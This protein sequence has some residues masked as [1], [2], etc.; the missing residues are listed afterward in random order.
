MGTA[1]HIAAEGGWREG[2]PARDVTI[3]HN[4]ILHCG[5]GQQ[6]CI[7]GASAVCVNIDAEM[8]DTPGLHQGIRIEHNQIVAQDAAQGVYLSCA[9]DVKVCHNEFSG[10]REAVTVRH[11]ER[12]TV[13]DN[14]IH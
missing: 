7:L 9:S 11:C 3:R 4:R 5:Y 6:G 14:H 12:V 8:A 13:E 1:I 10:C 2:V